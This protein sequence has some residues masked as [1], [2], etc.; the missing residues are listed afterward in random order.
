M[1]LRSRRIFL[2]ILLGLILAGLIALRTYQRIPGVVAV[3][4]LA[5]CEVEIYDS[6]VQPV[7]TIVLACPRVDSIRLWPLPVLQPWY[8][9]PLPEE[10]YQV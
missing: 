3:R 7:S 6:S 1:R 2:I 4:L 9:D 5:G 10:G 8:E